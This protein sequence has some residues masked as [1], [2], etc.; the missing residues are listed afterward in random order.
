[1]PLARTIRS[2]KLIRVVR[3][4]EVQSRLEEAW[5]G[6]AWVVDTEHNRGSL[7]ELVWCGALRFGEGSHWI[8]ETEGRPVSA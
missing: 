7:A 4:Q 8:E 5:A 2:V 6:T 3:S 1:M